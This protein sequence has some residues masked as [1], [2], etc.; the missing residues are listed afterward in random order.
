MLRFRWLIPC[1][2]FVLVSFVWSADWQVGRIEQ[3][4]KDVTSKPLYY[5]VNTPVTEDIVTYTIS[6]HVNKQIVT[7]Y[8][9]LDKSQAEPP[10]E[11]TGNTPVWI[12][13]QDKNLY[14]KSATSGEF[15]LT[16]VKSRPAPTMQALTLE[17]IKVLNAGARVTAGTDTVGFGAKE[18]AQP[19]NQ[20]QNRQGERSI[21]RLFRT[22]RTFSWTA[23]TWDTVRRKFACRRVPTLCVFPRTGTRRS[24]SRYWFRSI[25]KKNWL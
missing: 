18:A 12:Q 5:I 21:F 7:G 15:K 16:A 11:W 1:A 13:I 10:E 20:H 24:R 2:C 3:V 19:L 23:K 4:K 14:L 6:V 9:E 17:E 8:Y 25:K 22:S